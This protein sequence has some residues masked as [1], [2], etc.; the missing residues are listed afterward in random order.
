MVVSCSG[1][2]LVWFAVFRVVLVFVV[3]GLVCF[4]VILVLLPWC[5]LL[6][7]SDLRVLCFN[8]P[9]AVGFDVWLVIE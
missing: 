5:L 6:C 4:L 8:A 2:R 1:R 9:M 7:D 3:C